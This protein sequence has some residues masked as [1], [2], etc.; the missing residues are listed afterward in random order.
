MIPPSN[1]PPDPRPAVPPRFSLGRGLV[2]CLWLWTGSGIL[3]AGA[4]AAAS[5]VYEQALGSFQRRDYRHALTLL[6]GLPDDAPARRRADANNLRGAIY[7]RQGR[8]DRAR[9]AFSEAA[10]LD[11]KL[12][13]AKYNE[14]EVAFRQKQFAASREQFDALRD[15]TNRVFHPQ[16]HRFLDYKE[17]LAALYAGDEQPTLEFV[18]EH[19]RSTRPPLAWYYLNAAL[20]RQHGRAQ[21]ADQWLAQADA[22][23]PDGAS[24]ELYAESLKRPGSPGAASN[25]GQTVLASVRRGNDRGPMASSPGE[26]EKT[27]GDGH[28][29]RRALAG[30][31]PVQTE[32]PATL[33]M[34]QLLPDQA[35]KTVFTEVSAS[36]GPA[37]ALFHDDAPPASTERPAATDFPPASPGLL[38]PGSAAIP[39]RGEPVAGMLAKPRRGRGTPAPTPAPSPSAVP[40]P[41]EPSGD[42]AGA[43]VPAASPSPDTSPATTPAPSASPSPSVEAS[44]APSTDYTQKYEA[45]YVKFL[46]KDY[47]GTLGL[48]EEAD[49]I[50]PKQPQ[51]ATL[52][53]QVFKQAYETAYLAYRKSDF[54]T[55]LSL[56]DLADRAQP[57]YSDALNLRGLVFSKQRAYERAEAM[58]KRA[59]AVDPTLW[60]AKFNFAELPFNRGDYTTARSRFEDLLAE[61]DAVKRPREAE[62]TQYKVFLTLLLEGKTDQAR[63]FME[64]FNFS[65][66]TPAKYFCNAAMNFRAGTVDKATGWIDSAKHEYPATLVSI[67]ME[68]FYRLGWMADPSVVGSAVASASTPGVEATVPT[69][70][71]GPG[72]GPNVQVAV[73]PGKATPAPVAGAPVLAAGPSP[74]SSIAA[75]GP[76]RPAASPVAGAV[77]VATPILVAAASP[78]PALA[79]A[80][81]PVTVMPPPPTPATVRTATPVPTPV[82]TPDTTPTPAASI[83]SDTPPEKAAVQRPAVRKSNGDDFL[84]L[85]IVAAVLLYGLYMFSR[86]MTAVSRRKARRFRAMQIAA[87]K[88]EQV[89]TSR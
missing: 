38:S 3:A 69:V 13:A 24:R 22:R 72:A 47:P 16:E 78:T 56:L 80:A 60:A 37:S 58:F 21:K 62:L 68:P 28:P 89:E 51:T 26:V 15:R 14:A 46:E 2:A 34:V 73:E 82:P 79:P 53:Q 52:R 18:A 45:A 63:S 4:P 64:H 87:K 8:F 5:S 75:V 50:Q 59:I 88:S 9:T 33:A 23:R 27:D 7:L 12:W 25:D 84:R 57:N 42:R 40:A 36:N 61:T 39:A 44:V 48:L 17:R 70:I 81:S 54:T 67:F 66:A 32:A 30:N 83:V 49:A 10:R 29:T 85:G 31:A 1:L 19:R 74:G 65:G 86:V 76:S 35:D 11:P 71:P 41:A 43:N 77:P 6:D 20:E 55:A